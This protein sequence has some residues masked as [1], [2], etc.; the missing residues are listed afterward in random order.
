VCRVDIYHYLN[1][2]YKKPVAVKNSAA[3]R[4]IPK[5]KAIF[6]AHWS[7]KPRRFIENRHLPLDEIISMFEARTFVAGKVAALDIVTPITPVAA[8]TTASLTG[9]A[10][11]VMGGG[12]GE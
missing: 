4:Q 6:D 8:A 11:L 2:L 12:S 7:D 10:E 9:Y 1:T 3:L 5:L